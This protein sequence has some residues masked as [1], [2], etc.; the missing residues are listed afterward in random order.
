MYTIWC[1]MRHI[2][3]S[4]CVMKDEDLVF[5]K[6][7]CTIGELDYQIILMEFRALND[8]RKNGRPLF[9]R[10]ATVTTCKGIR[11][12]NS[13]RFRLHIPRFVEPFTVSLEV[14][15][16]RQQMTRLPRHGTMQCRGKKKKSMKV[17]RSFSKTDRK[18][19][20][21]S[22]SYSFNQFQEDCISDVTKY[23]KV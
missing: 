23:M 4:C 2:P 8:P 14:S 6:S 22:I 19:A 12:R 3:F 17:L 18:C 5:S 21:T 9:W 20:N 7:C 1:S 11:R 13:T 16:Y 15:L 10:D